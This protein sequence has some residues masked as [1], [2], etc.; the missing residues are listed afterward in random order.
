MIKASR[1]VALSSSCLLAFGCAQI[2][3]AKHTPEE[4]V[5]YHKQGTVGRGMRAVEVK[6]PMRAVEAD[7]SQ[8]VSKCI[9]GTVAHSRGD[10]SLKMG[11]SKMKYTAKV[12]ASEQGKSILS[13]QTKT[14]GY[15]PLFHTEHPD[16][17]YYLAAEI[18]PVGPKAT[19]VTSYYLNVAEPFSVEVQEWARGVKTKCWKDRLQ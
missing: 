5:H 1:L 8:Y 11:S 19:K 2:P 12:G 4:F 9:D 13:I 14:L 17:L 16:G 18:E 6:R 7:L 10:H 3:D 15:V